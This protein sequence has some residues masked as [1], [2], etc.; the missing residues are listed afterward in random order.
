[1]EPYLNIRSNKEKNIA[2]YMFES[3]LNTDNTMKYKQIS[4]ERVNR[5]TNHLL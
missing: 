5:V 3:E 2:S 1:M 4:L